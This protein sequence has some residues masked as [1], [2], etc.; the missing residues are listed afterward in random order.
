VM[1]KWFN[2][3]PEKTQKRIANV[4]AATVVTFTILLLFCVIVLIVIAVS[5]FEWG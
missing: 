3:L 5:F 1:R 4:I 2:G